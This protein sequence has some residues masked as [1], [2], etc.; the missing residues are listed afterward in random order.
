MCRF[1]YIALAVLLATPHSIYAQDGA[2]NPTIANE[3][4]E[5]EQLLELLQEQTSIATKTRLNADYVPG[6]VT[7]LH[8]DEIENK[9]KRTVWE[10]LALLPGIDI[11]VEEAGRKQIIVRGIGRTYASGNVKILLN[12]ISMNTAQTA[13]ANPV[14]NIPVEQVERIEV[15]RGP[16]SAIHGEFALTGVINVITRNQQSRVFINGGDNSSLGTGVMLAYKDETSPLTMSLNL[17]GWQTDGPNVLTG[18]DELYIENGGANSANSNAPGPTNEAAEDK[19]AVFSLNYDQFSLTAQWLEDGYGD[20]FGRNEFL[21]PDEKRIVISNKHQTLEIKQAVDFN[22]GWSSE[23]YAGWQER[24]QTKDDLYTGPETDQSPDPAFPWNDPYDPSLVFAVD[25]RYKEHR[26]NAGVDLK[27]TDNDM[28]DVLLGMEYVDIKVDEVVNE[29]QL[30]GVTLFPW[31]SIP[32]DKRRRIISTTLQDEI[33][34]DDDLT[35]TLG[36]RHDDYN[37]V[38]SSTT[39]R[40]AAVWRLDQNNILKA[41]YARAFRPPTFYELVSAV[42]NIKAS[43]ISTAELGYIHTQN[44][45]ELRLT[46]FNSRIDDLI[47]FVDQTGFT[48]TDSAI[49]SGLEFELKH[50]LVKTLSLDAN[51]SYLNS[52]DNNTG[53]SIADS[54]D[55]LANFGLNYQPISRANLSLQ[56]SYIDD[57]Y[58]ETT[59]TR[60]KLDGYTTTDITLSLTELFGHS[61]SLRAGIKNIFDTDVKYPAPLLTYA[62]DHPRAGRQWWTQLVYDF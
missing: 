30:S 40:I 3:A 24:K 53:R 27:W 44:A 39:P 36:M 37:D 2:L 56:Y 46:L 42:S 57:T 1:K 58:R 61:I 9:G 35:L 15:I 19:T 22:H 45:S 51:F 18:E 43:T 41:Q 49:I 62:D 26:N 21:P 29:Y 33:R 47:V 16:G 11:S 28:H 31:T 20:H 50:Q 8:G 5:L 38:G 59:D 32:L 17:A 12:G 6:M 60:D 55:W 25:L 10:A 13:Y 54:T 48:N 23:L 14:L 4:Q 7:V 52:S 34:L